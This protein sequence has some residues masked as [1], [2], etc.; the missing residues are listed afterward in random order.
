MKLQPPPHRRVPILKITPPPL[1]RR[2]RSLPEPRAPPRHRKRNSRAP[3]GAP[4]RP[5]AA[6]PGCALSSRG[7]RSRGA[8]RC[9]PRRPGAAPCC[10]RCNEWGGRGAAAPPGALFQAPRNFWAPRLFFFFNRHLKSV[11]FW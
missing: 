4:H 6:E 8:L 2:D 1:Y 3:R 10:P 5:H 11:I 7:S 9:P